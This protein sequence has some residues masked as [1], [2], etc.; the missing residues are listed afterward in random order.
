MTRRKPDLTP[1]RRRIG[2]QA[3]TVVG[4][5]VAVTL[6]LLLTGCVGETPAGPADPPEQTS[7]EEPLPTVT[8]DD[9][10]DVTATLDYAHAGARLPLDEYHA[11]SASFVGTVLHAINART[12]QCMTAKGHPAISDD[13]DRPY[14]QEDRMFGLWSTEYAAKYG[15][16]LAPEGKPAEVDLDSYGAEYA[17]DYPTCKDEALQSL[18]KP[19]ASLDGNAITGLDI[20]IR[21][22]SA[23]LSRDSEE[24]RTALE[25]WQTCMTDQGVLLEKSDGRPAASYQDQGRDAVIRVTVIEAECARTTGAVQRLYDL[26]ARYEAAFIDAQR[27][28]LDAFIGE[29]APMLAALQEVTAGK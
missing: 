5:Q 7:A 14:V 8:I 22:A 24:G 28:E 26:Q 15:T 25:N 21:N 1:H 2:H 4:A 6:A 11:D 12:D 19:L 18:S 17:A 23:Q 10:A 16:A 29:R 13:L 20:R 3:R 27:I 9:Y